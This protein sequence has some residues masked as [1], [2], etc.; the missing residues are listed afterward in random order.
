VAE[1]IDNIFQ[2]NVVSNPL[3]SGTQS[4]NWFIIETEDGEFY[5]LTLTEDVTVEADTTISNHKVE[6]RSV[7]SDNAV[8]NNRKVSYNGIVTSVERLDQTHYKDPYELLEGLELVRKNRTYCVCHLDNLLTPITDCLLERLSFTKGGKE[9]LT[10]WRVSLS[11]KETRTTSQA[12]KTKVPRPSE[13]PKTE[14]TKNT[15]SASTKS[16]ILTET[17]IGEMT[18]LKGAG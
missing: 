6:D 7:V 16:E 17:T 4:Q 9:G 10:T 3:F 5:Q 18:P 14:E 2:S 13:K 8:A 15:G 1:I 12:E 11:F